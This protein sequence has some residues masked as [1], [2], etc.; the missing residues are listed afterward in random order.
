MSALKWCDHSGVSA[1]GATA[2][3]HWA[4]LSDVIL[5]HPLVGKGR[6]GEE[7]TAAVQGRRGCGQ[8]GRGRGESV[9][10]IGKSDA[11]K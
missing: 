9:G 6:K 2:A 5:V 7:Q 3:A 1:C 8:N 11:E 10:K 4:C